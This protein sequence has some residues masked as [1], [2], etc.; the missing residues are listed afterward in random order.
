MREKKV[1][2]TIEWEEKA[3]KEVNKLDKHIRKKIYSFLTDRIASLE[4]PRTSGKPLSYDK[5]GLWRYRLEDFRIICR[6][7]DADITILVVQVGH[8]KDIYKE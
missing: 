7:N 2:W 4:N 8:R 3:L 5:Y 6:I 1:A